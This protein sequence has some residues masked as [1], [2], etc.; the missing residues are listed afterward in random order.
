MKMDTIEDLIKYHKT[1]ENRA[2]NTISMIGHFD[3]KHTLFRAV[4]IPDYVLGPHSRE[5]AMEALAEVL[6]EAADAEY[7]LASNADDEQ[8]RAAHEA[9]HTLLL[10]MGSEFIKAATRDRFKLLS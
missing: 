5:W 4:Q 3:A 1:M 7:A 10:C 6:H 8:E 2:K 9:T